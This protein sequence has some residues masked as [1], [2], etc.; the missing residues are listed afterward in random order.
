MEIRLLKNAEEKFQARLIAAVAFHMRMED[1][2]KA[3]EESEKE[4]DQ[5]WGAFNDDGAMTAHIIN[6]QFVSRL[7]GMEVRNGGIGAVSTLPEY[8]LDG[9]VKEIFR[10]LL[11]YAY[12]DGEVI[13]TLYPFSHSFYRKFGYETVCWKNIYEFS[14]AVLRG[15]VFRGEA[16]LWKTGDSVGEWTELYNRFASGY[17]L[18]IV[19]DD[20]RMEDHLKGEYYKDRKFCYFLRE[21][22]M[23]VAYL[24]FQDVRHDPQAILDVQDLAWDGPRGLRAILGFLAR[25]SAD[26]GTVRLFLPRDIELLALIRSPMAYDIQKSTEQS[27]MIRVVNAVKALKVMKKPAGTNFVIRVEDELIPENTG[28]WKVTCDGVSRS[29]EEP[30]LTVSEKALG[31]LVSGAVSLSE[32]LYRE[33]TTVAK[34]REALEHVFVRKPILVEEH[35]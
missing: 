35:F 12:R 2:A 3:R 30:D 28:V 20:R 1:P 31:Q 21:K 19:R 8:R 4:T 34:N 16:R 14:P 22:G 10:E 25:F 7:D 27:Y 17:N 18:S 26:Y 13:S 23:P 29:E 9:A 32:A 11:P 33:D 24:I 5:H 15:Y 6:N